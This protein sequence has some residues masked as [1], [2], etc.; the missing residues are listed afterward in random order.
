M[1]MKV[2]LISLVLLFVIA[3]GGV[4]QVSVNT[5]NSSAHPSAALDVKFNNKGFLPPRMSHSAMDSILN[6]ATGLMVYCTNCGQNGSGC[7]A[8]FLN[9][10]WNCITEDCLTPSKPL[11]ASHVSGENQITWRWRKAPGASG[12]KWNTSN[13]YSSA[14]DMG[15]DTSKTETALLCNTT[16]TRYVW[17]YNACGKS[18]SILLKD[19]TT[20]CSVWSC[21]SNFTDSRDGKSYGTILIG[22][23]CWMKQNLNVGTKIPDNENQSN[24]SI[25]E[26]YCY[27][28]DDANCSIYGGLYQWAET[29]QYLNGATNTSTWSPVPTGNIQGI[30]P[31]GWHVPSSSEFNNLS[32]YLGATAGGKLKETGTVHWAAPNTGATNESGFT[33]L[34]GGMRLSTGMFSS[35][36]YNGS[37]WSCSEGFFPDQGYLLNLSS[38]SDAATYYFSSKYSGFSVRCIKN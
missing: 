12:Y 3:F 38:N 31:A 13:S 10:G 21:G 24:N 15:S 34:P 11:A 27:W 32:L 5:D 23:Q 26:K 2:L 6:P 30:C 22:T 37:F 18:D 19:T 29:V 1:L 17:S 20:T 35:L 14:T 4:A 28:N 33:A 8:V 9:G 25:L 7:I 36:S 16:Y